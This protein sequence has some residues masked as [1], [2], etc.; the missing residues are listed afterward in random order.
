MTDYIAFTADEYAPD[1][2]ATA[3]HFERWFRNWIA[4]FEGAAG[5]PRIAGAAMKATSSGTVDLRDCLPWGS[6]SISS[7]TTGTVKKQILPSA[8]TALVDC[9]VRVLISISVSSGGGAATGGARVL[10]NGTAVQTYSGS[11]TNV[12]VDVSLVAGDV[13][14]VEA[15]ATGGSTGQTGSCTMSKCKYQVSERSVVLI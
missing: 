9:T 3:L 7:N 5:A 14:A 1:A 8:A 4:G 6:E 12:S 10:K 13:L 11:Q 2:P 15:T